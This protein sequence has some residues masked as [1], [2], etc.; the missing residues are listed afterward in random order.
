M[1]SDA[2]AAGYFNLVLLFIV[3]VF[4]V[5]K[6]LF[7]KYLAKKKKE[8]YAKIYRILRKIHPLSATVLIFTGVYHKYLMLGSLSFH[9]GSLII[10]ALLYMMATYLLG[11]T[12]ILRKKWRV[13]HRIGGL[14]VI[15][16]VPVHLFLPDIF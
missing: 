15:A 13:Y 5:Y 14:L 6:Y 4:V 12:N 10:L 2:S 7:S 8:E 16:S 1:L 11:K 3:L 9:S